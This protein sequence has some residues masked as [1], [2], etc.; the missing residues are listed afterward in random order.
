M[1]EQSGPTA[2]RILIVDDDEDMRKTLQLILTRQGYEIVQAASGREA[3]ER[4]SQE[5]FDIGLLDIRLPDRDGTELLKP[6][7]ERCPNM[8]LIIA[9]GYASLRSAVR[10]LHDGASAYVTKPLNVD[11]VLAK[12]RN[13]LE[14]QCLAEE[15]RRADEAL[16]EAEARYRELFENANDMIY[17]H[18][19]DGK[20]TSLNCTAERILGYS[21]EEALGKD[22]AEIVAPEHRAMA[23][24]VVAAM[25]AGLPMAVYEVDVIAKDGR[26]LRME[27]SSRPIYQD[28]VAVGIQGIA[29]NITERRELEERLRQAEK[30]E[31]IGRLAG[32][33]AHD[34][35]NLLTVINGYSQLLLAD[36][37][38]GDAIRDEVRQIYEA[39]KRAADLT[40]Q[41]LAFGRKQLLHM[42]IIDINQM[43]QSLSKMLQRLLH[44]DVALHLELGE[45]P[46][47]VK[48]DKSQLEMMLVNLA[49]NAGDAMP[50]GGR[51]T[52]GTDIVQLEAGGQAEELD[53]DPG[54]YVLLTVRDTGVGMSEEV[55]TH[56]FEPFFT[57]KEVGKGTGLGLAGVY[58][59]IKQHRGAIQV[60]SAI[61]QGTTF[62]IYLP[63][64]TEQAAIE[65][66][67]SLASLPH[68]SETILVVEDQEAV[69]DTAVR[70]L[71]TLG[72]HVVQAANGY[73]ALEVLAD[74]SVT[75]DAVITD[76]VM[77]EMDGPALV[78]QLRK[79]Y[80]NIKSLYMT[81][82][83]DAV[84]IRRGALQSGV[85]LLHKPFTTKE[86]ATK[87]HAV[88]EGTSEDTQ[89]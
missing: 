10:A 79:A 88:L 5:T 89:P 41:L 73:H 3:L 6:L 63:Y 84:L 86:L 26:R 83:A 82:Y 1:S 50:K 15:K 54:R 33:I 62:Y 48:A 60:R 80:P 19:L 46:S 85:A 81:G 11:E 16:Q 74:P 75:V 67:P 30:M 8:D 25:L 36:L 66:T 45:R 43:I 20:L 58:G 55:R 38:E 71:S 57:T 72:Y 7:K 35:N 70:M 34:F 32:H 87:L 69:R 39:G 9:T 42:E 52:I 77:P 40:Q 53:V 18:D 47:Y 59:T 51:L 22:I 24:E 27:V 37:S 21:R 65:A 61:G 13:L 4:A 49:V 31:A 64:A 17:I 29:R 44:E 14:R 23:R 28:G 2:K 78:A 56:L 12:V 76:I 68:G